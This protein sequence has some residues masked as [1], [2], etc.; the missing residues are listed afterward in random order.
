MSNKTQLQT[1]NSNLDA[2]IARVNAAKD[3]AAS[4]PEGGSD[5]E[6]LDAVVAEQAT[7]I[8]QLET[9]LENKTAGSGGT[10]LETCTVIVT[11]ESSS[12]LGL[13]AT[14]V[15]ENGNLGIGYSGSVN[16]SDRRTSAT[17]TNVLCGSMFDINV[18]MPVPLAVTSGGV[19][20][21][22][23]A[24]AYY[25]SLSFVAP[26]ESGAVGTVSISDDS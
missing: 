4:L 9:A 21:V 6:D 7:L 14:T 26:N 5:G 19:T 20:A 18:S 2:L 23:G 17:L 8:A 16:I 13:I 15:D 22:T 3:I 12:M 10:S 24:N 11:V 1:N 25:T